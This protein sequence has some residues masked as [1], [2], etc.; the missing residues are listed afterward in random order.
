MSRALS[1]EERYRAWKVNTGVLYDF[2]SI[3]ALAWP[4]L[5]VQ[6]LPGTQP[7]GGTDCARQ[8]ILLGT[9]TSASEPNQL[10]VAEIVIPD[11]RLLHR[12]TD[13]ASVQPKFKFTR[14]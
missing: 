7:V 1:A 10:L 11:P 5:T 6:W 4:S 9:Q 2:L 3:H 13:Y 14:R 12:G 8:K